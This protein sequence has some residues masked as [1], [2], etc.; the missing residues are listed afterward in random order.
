[1]ARSREGFTEFVL[2][3]GPFLLRTAVLLTH[4]RHAAEDLVQT[5]LCRA[6]GSWHSVDGEPEAYV[7]RIIVREFLRARGRRWTGEQ[8]TEHLPE[9]GS[10]DLILRTPAD[11]GEQT[12][13]R[14][15][16]V[17]AMA[18]LPR[19]QRAVVALRYYH[20]L[21]LSQVA[22]ELDISVGSVKTHHARALAA[23]RLDEDVTDLIDGRSLR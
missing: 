15:P 5:A 9:P 20:D 11:P 6:W 23:M 1:M 22:S 17:A 19:R 21:T 12:A 8:P 4:D 14:L 2:R 7:R 16:L 18:R 3:R 13:T 10:N